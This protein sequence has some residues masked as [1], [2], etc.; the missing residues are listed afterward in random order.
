MIKKTL[1]VLQN[2]RD[3]EPG[4]NGLNYSQSYKNKKLLYI[5]NRYMNSSSFY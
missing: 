4:S 1:P 3:G 2:I 5:R